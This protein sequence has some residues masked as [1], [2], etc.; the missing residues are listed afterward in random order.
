[1][2]LKNLPRIAAELIAHGRDRQT[3]VAVISSGTTAKQRV[4]TGDLGDIAEKSA[5]V[6]PPAVIVI[7]EVVGLGAE[8]AWSSSPEAP[9]EAESEARNGKQPAS[10]P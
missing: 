2:G 5:A 7:G 6:E 3:P 1:M 10:R 4:V 9:A 8:L